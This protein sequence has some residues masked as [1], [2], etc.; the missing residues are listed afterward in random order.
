MPM[1]AGWRR[2][3]ENYLGDKSPTA[4]IT[5]KHGGLLPEAAGVTAKRQA[6]PLALWEFLVACWDK[7][8]A[9]RQARKRA[10]AK[11]ATSKARPAS[12]SVHADLI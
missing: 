4:D 1:L 3:K 5:C 8:A 2:R 6:I 11:P 9:T 7:Q 12:A 10:A